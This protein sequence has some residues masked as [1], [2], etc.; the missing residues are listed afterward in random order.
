[1]N[2]GKLEIYLFG[3]SRIIYNDK[4]ITHKLST[5]SAGLL[6]FIAVNKHINREK[7]AYMFWEESDSESAKYNLR[8]NLWSMNKVF[9]TKDFE[10]PLIVSQPSGV[11]FSDAYEIYVDINEFVDLSQEKNYTA[12]AQIKELYS[13][14][15]LEGFYIKNSYKFNDWTFFERENYQRQYF[16]VLRA[17]L[18]HYKSN[19]NFIKA[20]SILDEMIQ[21]NDLDEDL[22]V[23]LIKIYIQQG[24]RS[25][26]LKEY[27]KCIHMLRDELNVSPKPTTEML[28]KLIK[29]VKC[30]V[31]RKNEK[32]L[33]Y[34]ED[35]K[36]VELS[37][38]T[39]TVKAFPV[40]I[41]YYFLTLLLDELMPIIKDNPL[42]LNQELARIHHEFDNSHI[43]HLSESTEKNMICQS[44][45]RLLNSFEC[46]INIVIDRL[47]F[48][49]KDSYECLK[50]L[51]FRGL[52]AV[53]ILFTCPQDSARYIELSQ[54]F[55]FEIK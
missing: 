6:F 47:Q 37:N 41:N 26:A 53:T 38:M 20:C 40:D 8:Y 23:E 18:D 27:N 55:E 3:R 52:K 16:D 35:P 2:K 51:L 4:E 25:Q 31:I 17:L 10:A 39:F 45:Y 44:V 15:F 49:D 33:V 5:K 21:L 9:K 7:L 30:S 42:G 50:Y 22:Y 36:S 19:H 11:L 46:S 34:L 14:E 32:Q 54:Y 28:L 1:M 43:I 13:G 24:N 29:A 48:I 12:L